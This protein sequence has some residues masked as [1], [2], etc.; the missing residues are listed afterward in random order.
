MKAY[1][2][3]PALIQSGK[4]DRLN[5]IATARSDNATTMSG[6]SPDQRGSLAEQTKQEW[7]EFNFRNQSDFVSSGGRDGDAN[8]EPSGYCF[9]PFCRQCLRKPARQTAAVPAW[10][11]PDFGKKLVPRSLVAQSR[12]RFHCPAIKRALKHDSIKIHFDAGNILPNL[13][14]TMVSRDRKKNVG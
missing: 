11:Q 14:I 9:R 6:Q 4:F 1:P 3:R 10:V 8:L 7:V 2:P 13:G 5:W 12:S